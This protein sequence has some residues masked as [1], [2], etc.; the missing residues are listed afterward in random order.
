[1]AKGD[2]KKVQTAVN[3]SVQNAQEGVDTLKNN[4]II[5]EYSRNSAFYDEAARRQMSDYSRLMDEY[6]ALAREGVGKNQPGFDKINYTRSPEM[7]EAFGGY[8][9][10]MNTGGLSA[11]DQANL[12]AR[13]ISPIRAVYANSINEMERQKN[14]AGGYSPN[15]NAA[16]A[17][18]RSGTSQQIADNVQN[19]NAAIA[20]MVQKG[21]MFGTEGMGNLS[22]QDTRFG[23]DAQHAN[24]N[25]ALDI[26]RNNLYDPRMQALNAQAS[27]FG[28]TPGMART[29]GDMTDRSIGN[30]LQAEGLN[31]N[32]GNMRIG[33]QMN[34]AQV[35]SNF[36]TAFGRVGQGLQMGGNVA[37]A[38]M[39]LPGGV[40][41]PA[42]GTNINSGL[43]GAPGSIY[44]QNISGG[45]YLPS[46]P[47]RY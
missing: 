12:R 17:R 39:G 26:A 16:A 11:E 41:P 47:L 8:R 37:G 27:L 23:Q 44:S 9:N 40:R 46:S 1:M 22:V 28:T 15:F 35:P 25:A 33:G 19:V 6:S 20:E 4:A 43:Y 14:L 2:K 5:P 21:K 10:F 7:N 13:G 31:Q 34:V 36:E 30:W 18:M 45:G 29:F 32:V 24:L 3:T 42:P 38:F